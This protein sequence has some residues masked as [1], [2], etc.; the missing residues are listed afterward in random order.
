MRKLPAFAALLVLASPAAQ[1]HERSL[2]V[3]SCINMGNSL[4]SFPES[5]HGKLIDAADFA[6]IKAAGFETVRIPVRWSAHAA[7]EAPYAIEPAFMTRTGEVVD[8]A[9]DAGLK[10][11][12]N[13]HHFRELVEDPAG[14]T[15]QLA[16]MWAQV[17]QNFADRPNETL[18][19][20]IA[21]EPNDKLTNANLVE[22]LGPA[23]AEIRKTNP[24]RAVVIGGEFW[25]GI[26]SLET[27]NLP[28]DPNVIPTFH[29]Y[30]PFAFT[31]QGASWAGPDIPEVGRVYGGAE[32][33]ER[34]AAD[35][36][37]VRAYTKRT[38][39]VPFIGESGAYEA[40]I[41]LEQRV[42]YTKAIHDTFA[43]EGIGICTWAY[44]NTFPFWD[45]KS[46]EWLPGM[47]EA[48]GLRAPGK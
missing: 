34:L 32:D 30:E 25:S 1:A 28:D 21:N 23:L 11:I 8:M 45:Q 6:R 27:L 46:G 17:A 7:N 19:F 47:L 16:A 12:L 48:M 35:L 33:S 18:W 37:K 4:E 9:L 36:E 42:A 13:D 43:P 44:T 31:H 20:E 15:A 22:T 40:H 3:G 26:S 39:L 38:G 41:P 10:V 24:E 14:N 2:P 5:S 29:Y